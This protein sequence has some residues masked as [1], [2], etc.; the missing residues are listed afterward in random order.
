MKDANVTLGDTVHGPMLFLPLDMYIGRSLDLYGEFS[1]DEAKFFQFASKRGGAAIDVGANLG[2][3]TV[4]MAQYFEQVF[5]F[6]PQPILHML[7]R[8]NL[9]PHLNATSYNAAV[10]NEDGLLTI[11][12]L[13]YSAFNNFGAVGKEC[14]DFMPEE[15]RKALPMQQIQTRM[16]DRVDVLKACEKIALL[17]VDVEGMERQVLEGA[18]Q[19]INQ[20][21]PILYVE[22]DKPAHS[23]ALLDYIYNVLAYKAWWHITFLYNPDN[24]KHNN[25][26][27]FPG[28]VS[29]NLICLP[30]DHWVKLPDA[31]P[32]TPQQP[33][34]PEGCQV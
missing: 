25:Q 7:L 16:L 11:P 24:F 28:M 13:D 21:Q 33:Y 5:A 9:A 17:K 19:L 34:V 31:K 3:H 30:E 27:V 15:Q 8:G 23:P 1:L 20:H 29:F 22:N 32:C 10:S 26:N 14:F 6:E 2:A 18:R 12:S 4:A